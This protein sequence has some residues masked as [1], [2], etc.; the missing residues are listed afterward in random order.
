MDPAFGPGFQPNF[1]SDYS[2]VLD[3]PIDRV[4]SIIGTSAGHERVTRLSG[5][6]SGFELL[7]KDAVAIPEST[8]LGD[9]HVRTR[10]SIVES[11][12]PPFRTL[13]RQ[14]FKL[15]ETV[16]V[17]FGLMN[18]QIVLSGT[19]TWDE[20]AKLAL[21]ESKT[22]SGTEVMVWKLRRF[23]ME[24]NKTRV[25]ERIQGRCPSWV[26]SIVQTQASTGH[27]AHMSLYH[28]LF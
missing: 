3:H 16:K 18:M 24:G 2:V 17:F 19:L 7:E 9:T 28:T 26:R 14:F 4:F 15:K 22:E 20:A 27:V 12:E 11:I 13:P 5:M 25:S 8:S 10:T 23:E 21:Y 6:C 1:F